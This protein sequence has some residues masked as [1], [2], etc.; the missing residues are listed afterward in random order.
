MRCSFAE[1]MYHS[2]LEQLLLFHQMGP[3]GDFSR[4]YVVSVNK[5]TASVNKQ[6]P[7]VSIYEQPVAN[8]TERMALA[9]LAFSRG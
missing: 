4:E 7:Y 3:V 2:I 9:R 1:L 6:T 5:Q 8:L